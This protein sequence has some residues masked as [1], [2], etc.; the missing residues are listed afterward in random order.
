[1]SGISWWLCKFNYMKSQSGN[2]MAWICS[3]SLH[4]LLI[5][6]AKK[7]SA[8]PELI[9][10]RFSNLCNGVLYASCLMYFDLDFAP[11]L[12]N[13][14]V[15]LNSHSSILPKLL[16]RKPTFYFMRCDFI[17]CHFWMYSL[18]VLA[19]SSL[20]PSFILISF[21]NDLSPT[22]SL[23]N[24]S[25]RMHS[26][27]HCLSLALWLIYRGHALIVYP[28]VANNTYVL[29][30]HVNAWFGPQLIGQFA[31]MF[32][33]VNLAAVSRIQKCTRVV[34]HSYLPQISWHKYKNKSSLAIVQIMSILCRASTPSIW[35]IV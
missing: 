15:F 27:L 4:L 25:V 34:V 8:L 31:G 6:F 32:P 22:L 11:P 13:P 30:P 5:V 29:S 9:L 24:M 19:F 10:N 14:I 3:F 20:F 16:I 1:M 21:V 23:H 2:Y 35:F 28:I 33:T 12:I 17:L 7:L 26:Q 18:T